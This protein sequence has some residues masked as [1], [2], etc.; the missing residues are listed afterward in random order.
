MENEVVKKYQTLKSA[1]FELTDLILLLPES[2]ERSH[3]LRALNSARELSYCSL[4]HEN[5]SEAKREIEELG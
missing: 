5:G 3:A 2:H 4:R 1:F